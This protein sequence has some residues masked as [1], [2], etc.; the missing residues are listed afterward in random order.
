MCVEIGYTYS[1]STKIRYV[2]SNDA[3]SGLRVRLGTAHC[4]TQNI[5]NTVGSYV[6]VY[7]QLLCMPNDTYSNLTYISGP[8]FAYNDTCEFVFHS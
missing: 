4:Y 3:N 7:L 5:L 8:I 1:A 6:D 2:H